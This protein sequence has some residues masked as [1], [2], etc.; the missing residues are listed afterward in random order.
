MAAFTN[1]TYGQMVD[2]ALDRGR[3][4][5]IVEAATLRESTAV[6]HAISARRSRE[7]SWTEEDH[8]TLL[9]KVRAACSAAFA[10][11]RA[12]T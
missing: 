3:W 2:A 9:V 11:E 5:S 7:R 4:R 12:K 10:K 8:A 6:A 1:D